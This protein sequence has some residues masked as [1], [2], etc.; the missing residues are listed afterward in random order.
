MNKTWSAE[1]LY[2]VLH[3]NEFGAR[4]QWTQYHLFLFSPVLL[5]VPLFIVFWYRPIT[6]SDAVLVMLTIAYVGYF[7][8]WS[9]SIKPYP[10]ASA[11]IAYRHNGKAIWLTPNGLHYFGTIIEMEKVTALDYRPS[12]MGSDFCLQLNDGKQLIF[13]ADF[14]EGPLLVK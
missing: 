5:F 10:M 8:Y 14:L 13:P 11:T 3:E 9:T 7:V 12:R 1:S 4:Y 2:S 6:L